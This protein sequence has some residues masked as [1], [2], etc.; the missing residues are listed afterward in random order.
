MRKRHHDRIRPT[1]RIEGRRALARCGLHRSSWSS[2]DAQL[3]LA[4]TQKLKLPSIKMRISKDVTGGFG[5]LTDDF[6]NVP[7]ISVP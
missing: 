7:A 4:T 1:S 3:R 5:I 2:E 6:G